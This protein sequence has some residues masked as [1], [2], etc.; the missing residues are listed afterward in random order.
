MPC[1]NCKRTGR[2]CIIAAKQAALLPVFVSEKSRTSPGS[3]GYISLREH[4][5]VDALPQPMRLRGDD[6]ALPYFFK[7]FLPM[8]ILASDG[9]IDTELLAAVKVSPALRDAV[10][11]IAILQ[12]KRH[13]HST[14]GSPA[15]DC[16][17]YQA[18]EAYDRSVC[19]MQ[20]LITSETF[21][22][23]PS[24]L[25]TTFLLGLFEVCG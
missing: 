23:D 6:R 10:D 17:N 21:L 5:V 25:W 12:M 14:F 15:T 3:T 19:S 11:A 2:L 18:L 1:E 13:D 8:N 7:S 22:D 9:T 20:S 16:Q 24:A 4:Q